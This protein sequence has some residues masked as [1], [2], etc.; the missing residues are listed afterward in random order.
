MYTSNFFSH[1]QIEMI[2]LLIFNSCFS[3]ALFT[4]P[5]TDT[6]HHNRRF[7]SRLFLCGFFLQRGQEQDKE[8]KKDE[9]YKTR[10]TD[11][12][13][14]GYGPLVTRRKLKN[15]SRPELKLPHVI[16]VPRIPDDIILDPNGDT[17]NISKELKEANS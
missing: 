4:H 15:N 14:G 12:F 10:G 7:V 8:L 1:I 16:L 6:H 11:C 5:E 13:D 2:P 17:I 9:Y 3:Q